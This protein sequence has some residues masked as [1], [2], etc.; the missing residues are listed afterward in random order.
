MAAKV[1][2]DAAIATVNSWICPATDGGL[3]Y[4]TFRATCVREYVAKPG[5][6]FLALWVLTLRLVA[7]SQGPGERWTSMQVSKMLI[8]LE[9]STPILPFLH[10]HILDADSI[11]ALAKPFLK[12]LSGSWEYVFESYFPELIEKLVARFGQAL[13]AFRLQMDK[14]P[15]L[16]K[17]P[18]FAL[19][20]HRVKILENNLSDMANLM[21]VVKTGQKK[22]NRLIVPALTEAMAVA[23]GHCAGESGKNAFLSRVLVLSRG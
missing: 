21:E 14:R 10:W 16:R 22:A 1:A 15:E 5:L 7:H 8:M 6:R 9:F 20:I 18:S 2:E 19:A 12:H 4:Q 17:I 3:A 13:S 23:Y 11:A